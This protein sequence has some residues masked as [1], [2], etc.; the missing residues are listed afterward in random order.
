[1]KRIKI[2]NTNALLKKNRRI[3]VRYDR[4]AETYMGFVYAGCIYRT[5]NYI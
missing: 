5:I 1:M 4:L 3:D 2:E